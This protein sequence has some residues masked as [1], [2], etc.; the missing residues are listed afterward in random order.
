MPS[1]FNSV[2]IIGIG[3]IGGSLAGAIREKR[4][5]REVRGYDKDHE[6]IKRA[7]ER[8]LIDS[9]QSN[10]KEAIMGAEVVILAVPVGDLIGVGKAILPQ[11]SAGTIIT[12]VGSVKVPFVRELEP[13]L[14]ENISLVGGHPIAGT[15]KSG[16]EAAFP[17]LFVNTKCILTP[18]EK[19]P[20]WA[21]EK[22]SQLWQGLGVEIILMAPEVHDRSLARIS[23][24]PHMVAYSLVNTIRK[25]AQE[26]KH[27]LSFPAGGFKDF[28]RVASSHPIMWRDICLSNRYNILQAIDYFQEQLERIKSH[29]EREEG[30]ALEQQFTL[31]REFRAIVQSSEGSRRK[32]D[33]IIAIDGPASAGKSTLSQAIAQTLHYTH[34]STGAIYRAVAWKARQE[35]VPWDDQESLEQ[36]SSTLELQFKTGGENAVGIY[37]DGEDITDKVK[38][39]EI[40]KGASAVSAFAGVRKAL[41][42]L[43]RDFGKDGGVVM[44]GRDIGTVI[45][46][47]AEL[48]FYLDATVEARAYRRHKELKEAGLNVDLTTIEQSLRKRDM[49]DSNRDLAPL[50]KAPDAIYI[51]T[52][53][54]SIEKVKEIMLKEIKG[55]LS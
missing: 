55:R 22:I 5:A 28:T 17:E 7:L 32:N 13:F 54:L 26:D 16:V 51:D 2:T 36:L 25:Q 41:L 8:N 42:E 14:S 37:L 20:P 19:T 43:Q 10:L 52:T 18:T 33:L 47:E 40:G 21:I 9:Y 29:I 30:E 27:M 4:V 11:L 34:I 38:D 53:Q 6:V 45:F 48:K 35:K 50:N 46:P 24:L 31:A 23:H 39:E 1:Q 49:D 15:E 12:D 44:E 3:L